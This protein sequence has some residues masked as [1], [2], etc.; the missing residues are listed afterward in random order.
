MQTQIILHILLCLG[1]III[2]TKWCAVMVQKIGLPTVVGMI[3]AGLLLKVLPLFN[4]FGEITVGATT[5]LIIRA[6]SDKF[7][8]YV[9]EL[10]VIMI[11]FSAGLGTNLRQL[12][13][14]GAK[15][16]IV[17]AAGVLTPL[18][19]GSAMALIFWRVAGVESVAAVEDALIDATGGGSSDGGGSGNRLFLEAI[20]IGTILTAT[21]VSITVATLKELRVINSDVG[22]TIVSAAIIDDVMGIVVL[23]LVIGIAGGNV[24][25]G[26]VLLKTLLF[27]LASGV[28]GFLL[29]HMFKWYDGRH[30]HTRR[31]AIYGLG[32]ALVMSYCA[33]KFFGIADITGAYIAGVIFCNLRDARYMEEKIDVN[34]YMLFS[35]VFFAS[36]GLKTSLNGVDGGLL[37]FSLCFVIIGCVAKVVGSGGVSRLLGFRG[38][39]CL[40][41]GVGMMVRGEVA[42]IV[43]QKGL[44][45]GLVDRKYFT[46]VILLIIISSM[47]APVLL[48][49]LFKE[50]STTS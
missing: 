5:D 34:S 14:S 42:L 25:I 50:K 17:A 37:L 4:G 47:V 21:S 20:F 26:E 46:S 23:T 3:I 1:L 32:C 12:V 10:G 48:K 9:A 41:I 30:E 7:I 39:E 22:Q 40:Q 2:A 8:T 11:M 38:R 28:V 15:A 29:Y 43:A 27:F 24:N 18:I 19:M 35:P 44:A 33:E 16:T 36:I 13:H 31:I 45:V 49:V 6:E